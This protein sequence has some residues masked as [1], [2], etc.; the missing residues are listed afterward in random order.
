MICPVRNFT[1]KSQTRQKGNDKFLTGF[2]LIEM[3]VVIAIIGILATIIFV[4]TGPARAKARDVKRKVELAQAGRFLSGSA[5]Y[6]PNNGGGDYDIAD[7]WDE[8][9]LKYPQ[10]KQSL[11]E[12]P[13]DPKSGTDL[14]SFYHYIYSDANKKCAVYANLENPEE[15]VNLTLILTPTA[16]GGTGVLAAPQTG[17]NG[18]NK[19]YQ[20]SN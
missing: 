10:I 20:V 2:T 13:R 9:T 7:L 17:W 4:A 14:K 6:E 8:I 11:S 12:P 3:L 5:C 18:T 16:G 1:K 15:P 19:Y